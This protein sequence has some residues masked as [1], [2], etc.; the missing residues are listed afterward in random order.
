M[1]FAT[2]LLAV[3]IVTENPPIAVVRASTYVRYY[4]RGGATHYAL[5]PRIISEG[6]QRVS[7]SS[8]TRQ[9]VRLSVPSFLP[10]TG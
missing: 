7:V 6:V 2:S 10:S 5:E 1:L 4:L 3:V 9:N 8:S